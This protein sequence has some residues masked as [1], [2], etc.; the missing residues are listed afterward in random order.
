MGITLG[1]AI[2]ASVGSAAAEPVLIVKP[3]PHTSQGQE[4]GWAADISGDFSLMGAQMLGNRFADSGG[5]YLFENGNTEPRQVFQLYGPVTLRYQDFGISPHGNV[6]AGQV[7]QCTFTSA[8]V[9]GAYLGD[10]VALSSQWVAL[11]SHNMG[12]DANAP[13]EQAN[14]G[15]AS[16]RVPNVFLAKRN[17]SAAARPFGNLSYSLTVPFRDRVSAMDISDTDLVL[18]GDGNGAHVFSYSP[19]ANQWNFNRTVLFTED[20]DVE[21]GQ[22]IVSIDGDTFVLGDKNDRRIFVY[23]KQ[24]STWSHLLTYSSAGNPGFGRAVDITDDRIA[25]GSENGVHFFQLNGNTLAPINNIVGAPVRLVAINGEYATGV[26]DNQADYI[27][28]YRYAPSEGGYYKS[29]TV[30]GVGIQWIPNNLNMDG[31]RVLSGY[32]GYGQGANQLIGS[33]IWD[34]QRYLFGAQTVVDNAEGERLW[35]NSGQFNW[36]RHFG[37]TPSGS[38]GTGP[39]GGVGGS[40]YYFV[41]TSQG[42]GAFYAGQTA[43]LESQHVQA[44]STIQFNFHMYGDHIGKLY[45]EYFYDNQWSTALLIDGQQAANRSQNWQHRSVNLGGLWGGGKLRFR[46]VANGGYKGDVAL[47]NIVITRN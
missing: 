26:E 25:V 1:G 39:S 22:Q 47:D 38:A 2:L 13:H 23:R 7:S 19:V 18:V 29:G 30:G 40:K 34:S 9:N 10:R 32:R 15:G 4:A 36:Q 14:C 3:T 37:P 21:F 5:A 20:L 11:S 12:H 45:L 31:E 43:M 24:G 44:N 46:Y 33:M 16:G 27:W 28:Q 42:D 6:F 41:E 17:A 35:R 8:Q